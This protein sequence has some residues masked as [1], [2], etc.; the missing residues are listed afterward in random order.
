[1]IAA[2]SDPFTIRLARTEDAAACAA[3]YRP[4]VTESWV[5]FELEAPDP[6]EMAARIA[7][8][9]ASHA[10]LIAERAGEVIGYAYASPHRDRAAYASSCDV[11]IYVASA[12]ARSGVGRALYG[13][14]LAGLKAQGLH[15]AFA[16]IALPNPASIALHEACGFTPLG[17]YREV[18]FKMGGWRDV[19]WWQRLL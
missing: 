4:Y 11:A 7:R 13:E 18:G 17:V 14:L 8:Y 19:G 10:W 9:G 16:G 1:M 2:V 12:A 5:S 6:A 3:I 15:A